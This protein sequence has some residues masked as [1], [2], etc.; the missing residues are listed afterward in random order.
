MIDH[1]LHKL[2]VAGAVADEGIKTLRHLPWVQSIRVMVR[3]LQK[4]WG[5]A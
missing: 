1:L 3:V 2:D 5:G 4:D